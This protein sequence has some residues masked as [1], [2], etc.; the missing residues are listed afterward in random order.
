MWIHNSNLAYN[1]QNYTYN[2]YRQ[3]FEDDCSVACMIMLVKHVLN[4][5]LARTIAQ[6]WI[7]QTQRTNTNQT[8]HANLDIVRYANG[9]PLRR[10]AAPDHAWRWGGGR[11]GASVGHI[12]YSLKRHLPQ[13]PWLWVM[14]GRGSDVIPIQLADCTPQRPAIVSIDWNNN[15]GGHVALCLG[16]RPFRP[17][18]V[19]LDPYHGVV[20]CNYVN[21]GNWLD[22]NT[23]HSSF[24]RGA[25]QG[26]ISEALFS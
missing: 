7:R 6:L 23:Q 11:G 26:L 19:F 14:P 17:E 9:Q 5:D 12:F 18:I 1:G 22:Y 21:Y 20:A 3:N 13:H 8:Q 10:L 15:G 24:N 16:K 2:V 4:R 25:S